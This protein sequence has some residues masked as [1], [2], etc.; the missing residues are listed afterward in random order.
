MLSFGGCLQEHKPILRY[1]SDECLNVWINEE[2]EN[3]ALY[4]MKNN[5]AENNCTTKLKFLSPQKPVLRF[6]IMSAQRVSILLWQC[7][8]VKKRRVLL[9]ME[10]VQISPCDFSLRSRGKQMLSNFGFEI[11]PFCDS[12]D[13]IWYSPLTF[14]ENK[15]IFARTILIRLL[16]Y[17]KATHGQKNWGNHL[18]NSCHSRC[19]IFPEL[20]IMWLTNPRPVMMCS[21]RLSLQQLSVSR[22]FLK[23]FL[24]LHGKKKLGDTNLGKKSRPHVEKATYLYTV[25]IFTPEILGFSSLFRAFFFG[26]LK[27]SPSAYSLHDRGAHCLPSLRSD[28]KRA[29]IWK[30]SIS[31]LGFGQ[32][33]AQTTYT[34]KISLDIGMRSSRLAN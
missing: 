28:L 24:K 12:D 23:S 26:T 16:I 9:L 14:L 7:L 6:W 18:F 22:V 10:S 1:V 30:I 5:A 25:P 8:L 19:S 2:W 27:N 15:R 13:E 31:L 20:V 33:T 4:H 32:L 17:L 3:L 21:F 11:R 34:S 29:G